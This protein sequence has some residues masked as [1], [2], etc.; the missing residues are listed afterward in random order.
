MMRVVLAIAA[1]IGIAKPAWAHF[2]DKGQLV[3]EGFAGFNASFPTPGES[4]SSACSVSFDPGLLYFVTDGWALGGSIGIGYFTSSNFHQLSLS[5]G[6]TV[7]YALPLSER[8]SLFPQLTVFGSRQSF[9]SEGVIIATPGAVVIDQTLWTLTLSTFVPLVFH[10]VEHVSL[11]FG[12][13]IAADV[14]ASRDALQTVR[15]GF[16]TMIGVYF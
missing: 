16:G 8:T 6:P 7:G 11:G 1:A 12:P 14:L 4:G 10:P 13:T 9:T 3:P 5:V 15:F 2:G